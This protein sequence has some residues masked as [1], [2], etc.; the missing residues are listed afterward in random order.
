MRRVKVTCTAREA[1]LG[2]G[3]E[4][5]E[6]GLRRLWGLLGRR[7]LAP[8]G[9]LWIRPSS[10]VHTVGMRFAIDVVGLDRDGTVLRVWHTLAPFRVTRISPRMRSV[11]ELPAGTIASLGLRAGDRL[12]M[13]PTDMSPTDAAS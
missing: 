6:T 10:G 7:G 5:A 8:G 1:C 11:M 2:D 3:I 12:T 4:V 9:G 13:S